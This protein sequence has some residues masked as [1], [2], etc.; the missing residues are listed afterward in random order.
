[1]L[2]STVAGG[3]TGGAAA[4]SAT[5]ATALRATGPL[6]DRLLALAGPSLAAA[7]GRTQARALSLAPDGPGALLRDPSGA[8]LVTVRLTDTGTATLAGLR[9]LSDVVSV[10]PGFSRA[11]VRI[12]PARLP[13]LAEL[14]GVIYADV[15]PAPVT[16]AGGAGRTAAAKP[17]KTASGCRPVVSEADIQLKAATARARS[18]VDGTGVTVGVLSD[19]YDSARGAAT[20]ARQDVASGDLPGRG[21]PCG[22]TAPVRVLADVGPGGASATD[23]GRAML[24]GVHDL[25]PGAALAFATAAEG[26]DAFAANIRALARAGADVIVDDITYLT[27]PFFQSGVID[28]AV[29]SVV[30]RGVSYLSSAGNSNLVL[31]DGR[32]VGSWE[33]PATRLATCPSLDFGDKVYADLGSCVSFSSTSDDAGY[34]LTIARGGSITPVLQWAEPEGGVDDDFDMFVVDAGTKQVLA[35]STTVQ[36]MSQAAVE[37]V[38]WTNTGATARAVDIVV[39]RVPGSTGTPRL[40]LLLVSASGVNSVEHDRSVGGDIVGPT[41]FGHN[42]GPDVISVA[43][44]PFDDASIVEPYSS[45]GPVTH[46]FGPVTGTVP[47]GPLPAPRV[48]LAPQVAATDGTANTFFGSAHKGVHRFHGTS[49]AAPAAAGVAALLHQQSGQLSARTL[50][51]ALQHTAA[52][53]GSAPAR[54]VGAGLVNARR[55]VAYVAKPSPPRVTSTR[56][57]VRSAVVAFAPGAVDALAA[58]PTSYTARCVS[59]RGPTR[60][61]TRA[62][63]S[64]APLAVTGLRRGKTY[65]CKVR[66]ASAYTVRRLLGPRRRHR[67]AGR[68]RQAEAR[69]GPGATQ[70]SARLVPGTGQHRW[71]AAARV[72]GDLHADRRGP[73]PH[74]ER[75]RH[76]RARR[77]PAA[78]RALPLCRGCG[79]QGRHRQAGEGVRARHASRLTR[80]RA[81]RRRWS[82]QARPAWGHPRPAWGQARPAGELDEAARAREAWA[83]PELGASREAVGWT[84]RHSGVGWLM[85]SRCRVTARP[86]ISQRSRSRG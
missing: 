27:E 6:S 62:G 67:R 3:A 44:V 25:A 11:T 59:D 17:P 81:R 29:T 77:S 51:S 58:P 82:R 33:T 18:H 86:T 37:Y 1:M 40:K 5:D 63:T 9:A 31:P 80:R 19:S 73:G 50:L 26:P 13:E 38:T 84:G 49:A 70:G 74:D 16:G 8:V 64:T 79:Q 24:Q 32:A 52:R 21:N 12:F 10:A 65:R 15:V 41:V 85:W 56:A 48:V 22:R 72:R 39:N 35:S 61:T 20:T 2:L 76:H 14:P 55:A 75:N 46:Y 68:T 34:G 78:R 43:A 57:K 71:A 69:H 47:A 83:T 60:T 53:V 30:R 66:A 4:A 7:P 28:R 54:A 45:L 42:G 36:A 23:E